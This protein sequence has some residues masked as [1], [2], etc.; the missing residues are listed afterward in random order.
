MSQ[1]AGRDNV[2]GGTA[3]AAQT[4]RT[5]KFASAG[6]SSRRRRAG[7]PA[8]RMT[9]PPRRRSSRTPPGWTPVSMSGSALPFGRMSGA[10]SLDA[11]A[12]VGAVDQAPL[13]RAPVC[14]VERH[15]Q[16]PAAAVGLPLVD[17]AVAIGVF[18]GAREMIVVVVLGAPDPAVFPR[19]LNLHDLAARVG[20][21]P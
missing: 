1:N 14:R 7:G 8:T 6:R 10:D 20:V 11:R 5:K 18:F 15:R 2:F 9:R 12:P 17:S 21:R 16:Q 3:R 19:E 13:R 4:S